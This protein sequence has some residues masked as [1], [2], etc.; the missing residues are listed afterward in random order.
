MIN[1][2]F[3]GWVVYGAPQL[4]TSLVSTVHIYIGYIGV[5]LCQISFY[6]ACTVSPGVLTKDTV[7][8]FNHQ[9][10]DGL[11]YATR[12]VCKTCKVPKVHWICIFIY[13]AN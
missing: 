8:A 11:L 9:P 1:A 5:A 6:W 13:S 2:G 12:T 4:P 7:N 3:M 10:F